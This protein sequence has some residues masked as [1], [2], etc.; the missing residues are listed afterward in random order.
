[1]N[2][3][4]HTLT[5]KSA[6]TDQNKLIEIGPRF[7]LNPIRIFSGS[8]TGRTLYA[9]PRYESPNTSR[10]NEKKAK[11]SKYANRKAAQF[12]ASKRNT[13][14]QNVDTGGALSGVFKE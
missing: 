7:V 14:H 13:V 6:R 12:E 5:V 11:G 8:F 1:M 4:L 10:R 2:I 3:L 9:N